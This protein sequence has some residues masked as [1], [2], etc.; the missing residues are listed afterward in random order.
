MG[1]RNRSSE[2]NMGAWLGIVLLVGGFIIFL[3]MW[4]IL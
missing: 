1:D 2:A 3:F 4:G